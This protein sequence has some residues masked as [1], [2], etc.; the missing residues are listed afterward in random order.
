MFLCWFFLHS[1]PSVHCH[2]ETGFTL[3]IPHPF[4][5]LTFSLVCYI[6]AFQ[7]ASHTLRLY[8][9]SLSCEDRHL[10]SVT[11]FRNHWSFSQAWVQTWLSFRT[12]LNS[13]FSAPTHF[14]IIPCICRL[15]LQQKALIISGAILREHAKS[16]ME[17]LWSSDFKEGVSIWHVTASAHAG[18]FWR[19]WRIMQK[20]KTFWSL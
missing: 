6:S 18:R 17:K 1:L 19:N 20:K 15:C 3:K 11:N 4:Y 2:S 9:C 7:N 8:V 5:F 12:R 13:T 16:P 14:H 10:P